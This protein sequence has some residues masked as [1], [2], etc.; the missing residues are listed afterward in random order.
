M[1]LSQLKRSPLLRMLF[2]PYILVKR[3][4]IRKG[5]ERFYRRYDD[6]LRLVKSESLEI[7]VKEFEGVFAIG[8]ESLL[9]KFILKEGG[10]EPKVAALAK[11]HLNPSK[12]VVDIGANVGFFSVLLGKHLEL[13][14]RV[15]A[16]EPT[17]GALKRL[18]WNLVHNDV[19]NVLVHEGVAG[20]SRDPVSFNVVVGR[21]EYSS[22][23]SISHA[24]A[25]QF[26]TQSIT[27]PCAKVDDLVAQ[28]ALEPGFL[29]VDVEGAEWEVFQGA[30]QTLQ[31]FRPV[32]IT[33]LDDGLLRGFGSSFAQVR[34]FLEEHGYVL[35]DSETM[36]PAQARITT[37]V[38]A[39]QAKSPK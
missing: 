31:R 16:V 26:A 38:L 24:H 30:V 33:E 20:N 35:F 21:E 1:N 39:L 19:S 34:A 15:L 5:Y 23:K 37:S 27:V 2:W 4:F 28:Y 12:D 8:K 3:V 9:A 32:I 7:E 6:M 29:K 22:M 14:R 17:P 36:G 25:L 18:R 10:F 11:E 13:G